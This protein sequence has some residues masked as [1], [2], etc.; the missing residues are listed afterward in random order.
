MPT[1]SFNTWLFE[2]KEFTTSNIWT[3]QVANTAFIW[4][5]S[6]S[7][8]AFHPHE[9]QTKVG[10]LFHGINF[11]HL[12]ESCGSWLPCPGWTFSS[13]FH[14]N[15]DSLAWWSPRLSQSKLFIFCLPT[16]W[17]HAV[18]ELVPRLEH[19]YPGKTSPFRGDKTNF[20]FCFLFTIILLKQHNIHWLGHVCHTRIFPTSFLHFSCHLPTLGFLSL[21]HRLRCPGNWPTFCWFGH[22]SSMVRCLL[23]SL[24]S[25][26]GHTNATNIREVTKIPEIATS[27]QR[28]CRWRRVK[29]D[30]HLSQCIS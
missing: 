29:R 22:N 1:T 10:S 7:R 28:S 15:S 24:L 11:D 30:P 27:L 20:S 14:F 16:I 9:S 3:S 4:P 18:K 12:E 21:Q 23:E 2:G 17:Q 26:K 6:V 5:K 25:R 19:N 13:S 8:A